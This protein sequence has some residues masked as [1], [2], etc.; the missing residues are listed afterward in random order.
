MKRRDILLSA[1]AAPG[2]APGLAAAQ[3]FPSRPITLL[4]PFPPGGAT[5]VQM[6]A[7]A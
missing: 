1:L 7:F 4:V 2:I 3:S 5:D 6:R